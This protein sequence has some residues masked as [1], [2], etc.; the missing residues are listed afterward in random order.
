MLGVDAAHSPD[1]PS[2]DYG[3]APRLPASAGPRVA[4]GIAHDPQAIDYV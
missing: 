4:Y 2:E 3:S 1:P